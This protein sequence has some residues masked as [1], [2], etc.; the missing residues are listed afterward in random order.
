MDAQGAQT[1]SFL[2]TDLA[3]PSAA[4]TECDGTLY[5]LPKKGEGEKPPEWQLIH[6]TPSPHIGEH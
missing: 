1:V 3:A 6:G 4:L 5:Y 2:P